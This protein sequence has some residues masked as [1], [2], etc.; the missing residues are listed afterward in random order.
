ME[1]GKHARKVSVTIE[2]VLRIKRAFRQQV[3]NVYAKTGLSHIRIQNYVSTLMNARQITI[4][5]RIQHALTQ[6]AA[7]PALVN[8]AT[9]VVVRHVKSVIAQMICVL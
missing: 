6:K 9:S 3:M 7:L 2:D 1:T 8:R 4:A 5:I